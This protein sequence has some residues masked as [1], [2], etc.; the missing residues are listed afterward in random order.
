MAKRL[1]FIL[2]TFFC[3]SIKAQTVHFSI[4]AHQDD[5]QLFMS[6]RIIADMTAGSKMVFI[7]ECF[8]AALISSL[9]TLNDY[10]YTFHICNICSV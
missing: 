1:H 5:W 3:F 6:S 9:Y 4:Q 10:F 7:T 8:S 2:L